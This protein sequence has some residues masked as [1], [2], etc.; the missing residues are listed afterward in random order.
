MMPKR[1]ICRDCKEIYSKDRE[2][3]ICEGDTEKIVFETSIWTFFPYIMAG[4]AGLF[5]I[6]AYLFDMSFLIWMTFPFIIIGILF[7]N[8]YQNK[9]D[10]KARDMIKK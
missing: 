5:L 3:K 2:C 9:I 10:E 7:D 4:I 1:Y 8:Y 6:S